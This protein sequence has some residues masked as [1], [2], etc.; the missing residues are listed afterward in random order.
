M[1]EE[2]EKRGSGFSERLQSNRPYQSCRSCLDLN[3]DAVKHAVDK[4]E[5][6]YSLVE[7]DQVYVMNQPARHFKDAR[8]DGCP[9]C[10]LLWSVLVL[11]NP[12]FRKAR[13]DAGV[14][15]RFPTTEE[16][17][18]LE[19]SFRGASARDICVQLFTSTFICRPLSF[20]HV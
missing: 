7:G 14:M 6:G 15:L 16:T 20:R 1:N 12:N 10:A 8:D 9:I 5:E 19:I 13:I 18:T 11:F 3:L 17:G 4:G 2:K